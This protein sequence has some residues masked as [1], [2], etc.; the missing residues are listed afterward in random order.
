MTD[1]AGRIRCVAAICVVA[2][3][4]LASGCRRARLAPVDNGGAYT[5][6]IDGISEDSLVVLL[7]AVSFD[8]RTGHAK[9]VALPR[10]RPAPHHVTPDDYADGVVVVRIDPEATV[11]DFGPTQS[12]PNVGRFLARLTYV[13]RTAPPVGFLGD[14]S[15]LFKRGDALYWWVRL[16]PATGDG[17]RRALVG[18][19]AYYYVDPATDKVVELTSTRTPVVLHPHANVD[20]GASSADWDRAEDESDDPDPSDPR[21]PRPRGALAPGPAPARAAA[22]LSA[23]NL[24]WV[25]CHG[26]CCTAK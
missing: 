15:H 7:K 11:M 5:D 23:M 18:T 1:R 4:V 26:G 13:D 16:T 24:S 21:E 17:R 2:A 25:T 20:W 10:R 9:T 22:P 3:P 6:A 8:A 19:G 12:P 14:D